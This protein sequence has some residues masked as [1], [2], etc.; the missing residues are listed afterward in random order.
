MKNKKILFSFLTSFLLLIVFLGWIFSCFS[1]E[2]E[3]D[4]FF[5]I[6]KGD[7]VFS[8]GEKLEEEGVIKNSFIFSGYTFITNKS[9]GL[10]AGT[11]H[12]Q[13]GMN[14]IEIV[15]LFYSGEVSFKNITVIEGWSLRE[16]ADYFQEEGLSSREDFFEITGVSEEQATLIGVEGEINEP[17]F[18]ELDILKHKPK[19]D[20][21]EGYL[22][23]DTY[24]VSNDD[25]AEDVV[26]M[27]IKNL[28]RKIS[29]DISEK[30]TLFEKNT[31]EV[32]IMASLLEKEVITLEDKRKVADILWRRIE[33]GMPLQIDATVNYVIG[34]K[35]IAVTIKETEVDSLYNTYK[36]KGLPKGPICNPGIESIEAVVTPIENNYWYYLSDPATGET[37]F[38]SNH[39]EHIQAKNKYLR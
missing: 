32:I 5:K 22:F 14:M 12:I 19:G 23:P 26:L 38:S 37:I 10:Q 21:L 11:Y 36:Y 20:S 15:N 1:W 16:I 13:S 35:G 18:S 9:K 8:I 39:N 28:E 2:T 31:H 30:I 24:R 29:G 34:K 6:E 3:E 4:L 33:V 27:M 17:L 25:T 7:K